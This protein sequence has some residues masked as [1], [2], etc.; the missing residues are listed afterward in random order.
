[1]FTQEYTFIPKLNVKSKLNVK[2]LLN[3]FH[4]V[5]ECAMNFRRNICI[6]TLFENLLNVMASFTLCCFLQ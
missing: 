4:P 3:D 1:M 6:W 2:I 5:N